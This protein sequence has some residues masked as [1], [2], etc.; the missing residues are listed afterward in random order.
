MTRKTTTLSFELRAGK[1]RGSAYNQKHWFAFIAK[2]LKTREHWDFT[3]PLT[4]EVID[5]VVS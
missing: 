4:Y 5:R 3:G 1:P 2:I